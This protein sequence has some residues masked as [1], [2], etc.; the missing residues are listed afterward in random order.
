MR[1]WVTLGSSGVRC[2]NTEETKQLFEAVAAEDGSDEWMAEGLVPIHVGAR[3]AVDAHEE[4]CIQEG[5]ELLRD[6]VPPVAWRSSIG[7]MCELFH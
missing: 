6:S 1:Q 3:E 2:Y 4:A 5:I 7:V